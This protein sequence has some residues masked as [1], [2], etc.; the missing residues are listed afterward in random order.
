MI[1]ANKISDLYVVMCP[2]YEEDPEGIKDYIEVER[3]VGLAGSYRI[4][5]GENKITERTMVFNTKA[6]A[7]KWCDEHNDNE[8]AVNTGK[9]HAVKLIDVYKKGE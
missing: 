1:K 9:Y 3:F 4:I 8:F 7:N 5:V 6:K 2:W